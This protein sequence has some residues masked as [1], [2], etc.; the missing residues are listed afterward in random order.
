MTKSPRIVS[1]IA[2]SPRVVTP[3]A[4]ASEHKVFDAYDASMSQAVEMGGP[5]ETEE[6]RILH[7][8]T[9]MTMLGSDR[10]P[11]RPSTS[12]MNTQTYKMSKNPQIVHEVA[13]I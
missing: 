1:P 12:T 8:T 11:T 10:P 5:N 7:D 2:K 13:N 9:V 3:I 4:A 6:H